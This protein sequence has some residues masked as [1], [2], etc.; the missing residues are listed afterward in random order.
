MS[1]KLGKKIIDFGL[2]SIGLYMKGVTRWKG[3]FIRGLL[4]IV[5]KSLVRIAFI[6]DLTPIPFNG[7]S[8]QA[9]ARRRRR[10]KKKYESRRFK[11]EFILKSKFSNKLKKFT[12][13]NI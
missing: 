2:K 8:P 6:R 7:C 11:K 9:K 10:R 3:V 13:G 5:K 12:K 4:K 1:E